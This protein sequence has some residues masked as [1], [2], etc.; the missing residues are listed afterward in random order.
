M[1]NSLKI[2]PLANAPFGVEVVGLRPEM[3]DTVTRR[4]ILE[5]CSEGH[6]LVC[7]VFDRLLTTY[8]LH[9]LTEIFG[10]SEFASGVI[11]GIGKKA[12]KGEEN[13]SLEEQIAIIRG[14]GEDPYVTY[15]GN[16]NPVTLG[17]ELIGPEFYGEWQW[18]T[19]MSFMEKP[20]TF[21]LMHARVVPPE[22]GDT[23][24]CSQVMAAEQ[25]PDRL[26][27]RVK[28]LLIKHDGTYS[29]EGT[30]RS[31]F[32]HPR[33][34]VDSF[35]Y[36]H[37][38]IRKLPD[39]GSEA[40]FLGRRR[41]A[42]IPEW[43]LQESEVFLDELWWYAT[44]PRFCYR[45]KWEVGQVVVWDNRRLLHMRHPMNMSDARFMWRTQTKGEPV[46]SA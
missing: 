6:G 46:L 13:L 27:E 2:R 34:P 44:Q 17:K 4:R 33:S 3:L 31:G 38:V 9:Q 21:S 19:D 41:H 16:L 25:L 30:L 28:G 39:G 43:T 11:N 40:L 24:F 37:P 22:G 42:Y 12:E 26:R 36:S 23:G 5:A 29:S 8:E 32:S 18:H 15:I 7:F 10:D 35:G 45:H 14:R 1:K 20:P